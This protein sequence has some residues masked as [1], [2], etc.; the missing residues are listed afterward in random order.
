MDSITRDHQTSG[1]TAYTLFPITNYTF[2][3]KAPKVEK[4]TSVKERLER[5]RQKYEKEGPRFSV[6]GILLVQEHGHPHV[7]L[8]QIGN[9]FFKLPGGRL[10]PGED[11]IAGLKRKLTNN[12][13]P[14][15][16]G[17]G[18]EW[19]VGECIGVYWRPNFETILYPYLPPHITRPK[20]CK[21]LFVSPLPEKCYFAVPKNLRLLA[22]PLFELYD[23][24]QRYGP[25]ISAIPQM[26]SRF[27]LNF[28]GERESVPRAL[29][30]SAE[31]QQQQHQQGQ[32]SAMVEVPPSAGIGDQALPVH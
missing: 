8:L 14:P 15:N 20:E 25:I 1:Q 4:D 16:P 19:E 21:K 3:T 9:T 23:N 30:E 17:L 11:E 6:E 7:L 12:L 31:Q 27:R 18:P 13:S 10:R 28:A 5:M 22:V 24:V 26:L 32:Q 2:G 29:L